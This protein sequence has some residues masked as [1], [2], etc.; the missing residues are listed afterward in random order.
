MRILTAAFVLLLHA[1]SAGAQWR[2]PPV[3]EGEWT[4][5]QR[6]VVARFGPGGRANNAL[7][8][9]LR[10]P[11]LAENILPFERYIA[12]ESTLSPRHRALLILRTAW[13]CRSAYVWAQHA[14]RARAAG[15]N[16]G[17]LARIAADPDAPGWDPFEA[18]L[19]RTVDELFV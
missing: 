10:H 15:L 14:P 8:V 4:D 13:V 6:G 2:I 17:E 18:V 5:A 11:V 16:G 3:A 7:R 1:A 9:Y 19:L 12:E